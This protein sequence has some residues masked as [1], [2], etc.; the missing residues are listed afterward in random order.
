[1]NNNFGY[2]IVDVF[3]KNFNT[4]LLINNINKYKGYIVSHNCASFV[5]F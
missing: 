3:P 2:Y 4:Y 5:R 1:M